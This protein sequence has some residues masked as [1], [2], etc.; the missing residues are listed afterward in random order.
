MS[1]TGVI[2]DDTNL[3]TNLTVALRASQEN[4]R[5]KTRTII[6]YIQKMTQEWKTSAQD[7]PY[8]TFYKDNKFAKSDNC[9]RTQ[10]TDVKLP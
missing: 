7:G 9:E 1:F 3:P 4:S 2:Y 5:D 6:T 10:S 8:N